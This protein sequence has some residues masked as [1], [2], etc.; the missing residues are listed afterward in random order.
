[1]IIDKFE[2]YCESDQIKYDTYNGPPITPEGD[3]GIG[4][5]GGCGGGRIGGEFDGNSDVTARPAGGFKWKMNVTDIKRKKDKRRER[6]IKKLNLL[7]FD[8]WKKSH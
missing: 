3:P 2:L 1:M 6:A 8:E 4:S 5:K 7:S